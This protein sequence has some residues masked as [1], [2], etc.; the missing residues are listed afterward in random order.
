MLFDRFG[1]LDI[2]FIRENWKNKTALTACFT[3]R[4]IEKG[5]Y[6]R[7][8]GTIPTNKIVVDVTEI[9]I[10]RI[11]T[12]SGMSWNQRDGYGPPLIDIVP[13]NLGQED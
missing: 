13:T 12:Y 5:Q 4:A 7:N 1:Q 8:F 11:R 3:Q 2:S 9:G 6:A 10:A